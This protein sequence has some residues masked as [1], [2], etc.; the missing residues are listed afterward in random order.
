MDSPN[1]IVL[2]THVS[3]YY[4]KVCGLLWDIKMKPDVRKYTNLFEIINQWPAVVMPISQLGANSIK[5]WWLIII[6]QLFILL[7]H[8]QS[9][10]GL[11]NLVCIKKKTL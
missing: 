8:S 7:F 11:K 4:P 3:I 5:Y 10:S 2:D 1:I 9:T 6:S